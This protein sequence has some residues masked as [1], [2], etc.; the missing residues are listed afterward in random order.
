MAPLILLA[1]GV[2]FNLLSMVCLTFLPPPAGPPPPPPPQE[3]EYVI[4]GGAHTGHSGH[5]SPTDSIDGPSGG[6]VVAVEMP[7]VRLR[8]LLTAS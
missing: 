8:G 5:R 4:K 3:E 7:K 6:R 1:W 2:V